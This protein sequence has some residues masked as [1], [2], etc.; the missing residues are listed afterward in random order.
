MIITFYMLDQFL[1]ISAFSV[2]FDDIN[3]IMYAKIMNREKCLLPS[4]N[5]IE[6]CIQLQLISLP[7]KYCTACEIRLALYRLNLQQ[8]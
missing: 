3:L 2:N 4:K 1:L 5:S 6:N 7:K 8:P